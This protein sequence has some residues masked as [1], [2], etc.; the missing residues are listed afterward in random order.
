[1][2]GRGRRERGTDEM[3]HCRFLGEEGGKRELGI[4]REECD[5]RGVL[6]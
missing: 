1:M 4:E 2:T 5:H 6:H 3:E